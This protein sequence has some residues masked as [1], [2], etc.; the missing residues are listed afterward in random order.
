[1][2]KLS[3]SLVAAIGILA[4]FTG[5]AFASTT[6]GDKTKNNMNPNANYKHSIPTSEGHTFKNNFGTVEKETFNRNYKQ[7]N[8]EKRNV[9]F[10]SHFTKPEKTNNSSYKHPQGL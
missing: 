2:K 8:T 3:M 9:T 5:S 4:I 1:M 10:K 7:Q 6:D